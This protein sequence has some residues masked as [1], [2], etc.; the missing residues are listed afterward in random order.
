MSDLI[1]KQA[2]IDALDNLDDVIYEVWKIAHKVIASL[3][4]AEKRGRWRRLVAVPQ[5]ESLYMGECSECG[6]FSVVGKFCMECG[7]RLEEDE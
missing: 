4:S 6:E 7:A 1:S 2:A 5:T 3:P